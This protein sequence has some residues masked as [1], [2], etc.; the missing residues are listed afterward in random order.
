V[1]V[2]E[3]AFLRLLPWMTNMPH[4]GMFTAEGGSCPYCGHTKLERDGIT[5]TNV[6]SY[7][8]FRCLNCKGWARGTTTLQDPTRT[9]PIR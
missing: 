6:Q 5:H 3:K 4:I 2:T 1:N 7:Y 9:R 8:L